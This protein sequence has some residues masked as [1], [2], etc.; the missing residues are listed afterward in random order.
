MSEEYFY[1]TDKF[2]QTVGLYIR[3]FA[4]EEQVKRQHEQLLATRR[5]AMQLDR[6]ERVFYSK[7]VFFPPAWEELSQKQLAR[8]KQRFTLRFWLWSIAS[9]QTIKAHC[10]N[11]WKYVSRVTQNVVGSVSIVG[12]SLLVLNRFLQRLDPPSFQD[13]LFNRKVQIKHLRTTSLTAIA[14]YAII[15]RIRFVVNDV[16]LFDT[17]LKYKHLVAHGNLEDPLSDSRLPL[18][19]PGQPT[20]V[21]Q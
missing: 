17:G 7:T 11:D 19:R 8:T 10:E 15:N 13:F 20:Q 21:P 2:T 5:S 14:L 16:Y 9:K 3:D 1:H 6:S 18:A 12:L 4:R